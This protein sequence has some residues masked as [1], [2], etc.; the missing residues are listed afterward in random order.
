MYERIRKKSI[1]TVHTKLLVEVRNSDWDDTC[2]DEVGPGGGEHQ[3]ETEAGVLDSRH[4]RPAA[5]TP[6]QHCPTK[7]YVGKVCYADVLRWCWAEEV[8]R[9]T[10]AELGL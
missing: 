1:I 4:P 3:E 6:A 5:A 10:V 2:G 8:L 9:R 7:V